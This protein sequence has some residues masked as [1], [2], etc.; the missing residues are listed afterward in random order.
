[1]TLSLQLLT[2]MQRKHCFQTSRQMHLLIPD[3]CAKSVPMRSF[4]WSLFSCI[5]NAYREIQTRKNFSC[6]GWCPTTKTTQFFHSTLYYQKICFGNHRL[7]HSKTP[8]R[9]SDTL[10]HRTPRASI[11]KTALP[12]VTPYLQELRHWSQSV[13]DH[14][15]SIEYDLQMHSIWS[16]FRGVQIEV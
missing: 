12:I 15:N 1:M 7:Q 3:H 10:L 13:R 6:N 4:L 8:L 9:S 2:Q 11:F 5:W 16:Q 14:W